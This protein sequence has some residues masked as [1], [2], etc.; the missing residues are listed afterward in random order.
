MADV[1]AVETAAKVEKKA[2]APVEKAPAKAA[3]PEVQKEEAAKKAPAKKAPVKKETVKKEP[4]KK[5]AAKK[6]VP[7]KAEAPVKKEVPA[8]KET[9]AAKKPAAKKAEPKAS[10]TI[11]YAGKSVVAKD[12]LAQVKKDFAKANKGVAIKSID[13]YVKP[14][15]SVAYYVVNGIGSDDYKIYL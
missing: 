10:V 5:E 14:E 12:I 8:K 9:A 7:A 11:E 2:E 6:E 4:V 13:I 15:E 3:A 1:K